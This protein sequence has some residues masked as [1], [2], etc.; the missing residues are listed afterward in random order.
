MANSRQVVPTIKIAGTAVKVAYTGTQGVTAAVGSSLAMVCATSDCHIVVG[1][2][3]TATANDT[4]L[5]AKTVVYL[6]CLTT[7]K[8]AAIQD[9]AGG[10]LFV[11]P[12][13]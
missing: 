3:P 8:I 2:S 1:S 4:F 11:T 9:S 12:C 5:P 7:D 6:S 13:Q 10:T